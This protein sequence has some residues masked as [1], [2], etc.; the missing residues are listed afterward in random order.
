[1]SAP[2]YQESASIAYPELV[3]GAPRGVLRD[4]FWVWSDGDY[5]YVDYVFRGVA[6]AARLL[7]PPVGLRDFDE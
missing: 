5:S 6:K 3:T 7:N 1:M 4:D 2:V